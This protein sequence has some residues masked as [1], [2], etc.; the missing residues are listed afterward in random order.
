[1]ST[2]SRLLRRHDADMPKE[3]PEDP[4]LEAESLHGTGP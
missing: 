4:N 3:L 1:M 2:I